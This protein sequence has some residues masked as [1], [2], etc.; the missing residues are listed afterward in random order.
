MNK[1]ALAAVAGALMSV[2]GGSAVAATAS[3]SNFNVTVAL[4]PKCQIK[5][6]ADATNI[7]FGTYVAFQT[8]AVNPTPQTV[9][10]QCSANQSPTSIQLAAPAAVTNTNATYSGAG[11]TSTVS[12]VLKGLLYSLSVGTF[13][14]TPTRAATPAAAGVNGA[15]GTASIGAEWDLTI[16]PTMPANQGGNDN[17]TNTQHTYTLILNY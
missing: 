8:S 1:L 12:G 17:D 9:T 14:T 6:G 7:S 3:S 4:T 16:T 13:S 10:F 11:N 15:T 5:A 2:L